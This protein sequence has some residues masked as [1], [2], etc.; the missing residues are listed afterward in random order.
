[1]HQRIA[2]VTQHVA[3]RRQRRAV[4]GNRLDLA[5]HHYLASRV[6]RHRRHRNRR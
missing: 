6:R 2:V 4:R 1:M 5:W 3:N